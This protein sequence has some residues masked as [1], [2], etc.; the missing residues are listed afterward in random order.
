MNNYLKIYENGTHGSTDWKYYGNTCTYF[1]TGV[2]SDNHYNYV[3]ACFTDIDYAIFDDLSPRVQE[4]NSYAIEHEG[5]TVQDEWEY[6]YNWLYNLAYAGIWKEYETYKFCFAESTSGTPV[7]ADYIEVEYPAGTVVSNDSRFGALSQAGVLTGT[8]VKLQWNYVQG[9]PMLLL[10][11]DEIQ[12]SSY[13]QTYDYNDYVCFRLHDGQG[14]SDY[15]TGD[16]DPQIDPPG[17]P[18]DYEDTPIEASSSYNSIIASFLTNF[19]VLAEIDQTNLNIVAEALN[20]DIDLDDSIPEMLAKI[21]RSIIQKNIAEGVLSIKIIPIPN[22]GSLP[23]STGIQ[24]TLFKPLGL[25]AVQGKRLNNTIKKYQIGSMEVH[26]IYG[27]Y[28]D[29]MCEYSIYLPF[30]GIHRLD[31]DIIVGNILQIYADIDFLTGSILYH[32]IVNDRNTSRDIYTF[33]GECAIE[34]P[35]TGVDYTGKYQTIMNGVFSG[36]GMVAGA[37]A[38]G[39]M[40]AGAGAALSNVA[41]S[42][43]KTI[44]NATSVKGNYMQSGKLIP[45]SSALSVLYPYL[46]ISKPQD[47]SPDYRSVKGKPT[48]KML[49]LSA[50]RGFTTISNINLDHIAYAT[51]EDKEALR[52]LLASGVYF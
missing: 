10:T 39:P 4:V 24:E 42:G 12:T 27:D 14:I 5:W 36:V 49:T 8:L 46:I 19:T 44:G 15:L 38:G 37:L 34:L 3:E 2:L 40:G 32:L 35:I 25:P 47:I 28:R 50:L 41:M 33:T 51:D 18:D 21:G 16:Q 45:N 13:L 23:Y 30:S 52:G 7:K 6:M 48:H 9:H 31:A 29:F 43:L 17:E 20:N 26:K 11:K 1:G 22:G